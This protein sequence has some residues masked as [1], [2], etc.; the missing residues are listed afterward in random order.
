MCIQQTI[1]LFKDL[2]RKICLIILAFLALIPI[3]ANAADSTAF[4]DKLDLSPLRALAV[5]HNQRVKTLDSFA[6]ETLEDI[7]GSGTYLHVGQHG[8]NSEPAAADR[9]PCFSVSQP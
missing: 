3:T 2:M 7:S 5:Q 8:E 6:R 4:A 9:V 1:G